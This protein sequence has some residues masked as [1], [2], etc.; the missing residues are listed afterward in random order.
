MN[1]YPSGQ[2]HGSSTDWGGSKVHRQQMCEQWCIHTVVKSLYIISLTVQEI[3]QSCLKSIQVVRC[4]KSGFMNKKGLSGLK[5]VSRSAGDIELISD[6][7]HFIQNMIKLCDMPKPVTQFQYLRLLISHDKSFSSW[8]HTWIIEGTSVW[9]V[10]ISSHHHLPPH[11]RT[12]V[13]LY[14]TA[15]SLSYTHNRQEHKVHKGWVNLA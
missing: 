6:K 14:C 5:Y 7:E 10:P 13:P 11:S 4:N 8:E 1:K 12:T 9:K 15:L 3:I 2:F